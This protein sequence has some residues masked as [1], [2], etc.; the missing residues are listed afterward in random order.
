MI[1]AKMLL[2]VVWLFESDLK[3]SLQVERTVLVPSERISAECH[4][5]MDAK[6][7]HFI[8]EE[9]V[10]S[11]RIPCKVFLILS[12]GSGIEVC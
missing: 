7:V 11:P 3:V 8:S 5:G 2:I 9:G 12:F 6:V 1:C 10:F 4:V